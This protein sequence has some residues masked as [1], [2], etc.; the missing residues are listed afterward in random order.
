MGLNTYRMATVNG[1]MISIASNLSEDLAESI[2]D[3]VRQIRNGQDLD[4]FEALVD[5]VRG[6]AVIRRPRYRAVSGSWARGY[7]LA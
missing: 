7:T 4:A 5:D 2:V 1:A 3:L 6:V